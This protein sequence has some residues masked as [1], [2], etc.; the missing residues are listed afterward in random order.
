G[1]A[2]EVRIARHQRD[3]PAVKPRVAG[4][5]RAAVER[6]H[7]EERALV[8]NRFDDASHLVRLSLIVRDR[9]EEPRV[10]ALWIVTAG[11][12]RRHV[13]DRRREVREKA[14]RAREGFFLA[15]DGV[16]DGAGLE[17]DLPA[18]ELVLGELLAEALDHRRAGDEERREILHHDRVVRRGEVGGAEAGD[19]AEAERHARDR[20][21]VAHDPLPAVD[22]RHI[23]AARRLDRLHGAAAAGALDQSDQRQAQVVGH[24]LALVVLAANG[25]VGRAAAHGEVVAADHDRPPVDLGAAEHEVR[26]RE[27][28]EIILRVVSRAAGD[29]AD[30]V[31]AAG[32]GELGDALENRQAAAVVLALHAL[33]P[34]Q[35]RGELLAAPQLVQLLLPVHAARPL[36]FLSTAIVATLWISLAQ[37]LDELLLFLLR[38]GVEPAPD[39]IAVVTVVGLGHVAP[40]PGPRHYTGRMT[41]SAVCYLSTYMRYMRASPGGPQPRDGRRRAPR[42]RREPTGSEG[43]PAW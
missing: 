26:R 34:A 4:D 24:P 35:L 6:R 18:A 38:Q 23:G 36:L 21:H 19:R 15:V 12:A 10:A 1:A 13:V 30:L 42:A 22:P 32:V 2:V 20:R 25:R 9:L 3:R 5:D 41:R 29:L 37:E 11:P 7:L 14:P 28:D 8:D 27:R 16:V 43:G 31:E 39:V 17:L 33:G 40:P